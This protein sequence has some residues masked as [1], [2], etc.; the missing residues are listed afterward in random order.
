MDR[1]QLHELVLTLKEEIASGRI[2][3]KSAHTIEALRKV[4]YSEDGKV[5]PTT[6]D[7]SVRALGLATLAGVSRRQAKETSLREVQ[8]AY[9]EM[10]DSFFGEAF[11][12]M[13]QRGLNAHDMASVL[14]RDQKTVK[15]FQDDYG[16]FTTG[17]HDFWHHF[18]PAL[19]AHID[20]LT[21]LKSVF[22][23]D[24][25]PSYMS[26]IACSVGLYMDTVVLPDPL[27]RLIVY[28]STPGGLKPQHQFF[29]LTKHALNILGYR[30]LALAE[31]EPPIVV[32]VPG[33]SADRNYMSLLSTLGDSDVTEHFSRM[34]V[35]PF[36]NLKDIN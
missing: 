8:S 10:L 12:E 30:E 35:R 29:Y 19:Q 13:R 33:L 15:A 20:D 34:F 3:V 24:I 36:S 16:A 14:S 6:V 28:W 1:E 27:L 18:G 25:S 5:D 32:V 7:S 17:V 2:V 31:V 21:S 26:N 11:Y 9:F 23:G 4:R 22:S